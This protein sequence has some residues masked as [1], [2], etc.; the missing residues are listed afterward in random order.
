MKDKV[1]IVTGA[2]SGIGQSIAVKLAE[3]GCKVI[4]NCDKNVEGAKETQKLAGKNGFVVQADV[5][6]VEDCKKLV[7]ATIKKFG[8]IDI[9]V[10]NAGI[11]LSMPLAE[12]SE[13]D[14]DNTID[15]NLKGAFFL[16]KYASEHMRNGSIVNISS[17]RAFNSREMLSVYAASKAGLIGLTKNLAI[18]LAGKNIR[19]NAI[20]PGVIETERVK[21]LPVDLL[22][23]F[24]ES[25]LLKRLGKPDE[26][27]NVVAFL[28]SDDASYIDG[29]VI[30]VDGGFSC[31]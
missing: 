2:S 5:S 8:K 23:K 26:I 14:W 10:N 28:S 27:A 30:V 7:D 25:A 22:E 9:L 15:T 29:E 18:D 13:K 12:V 1:V 24:K 17:V 16:S 11:T 31:Q 19:V 6:K 20:A 3:K 21:R 4:I